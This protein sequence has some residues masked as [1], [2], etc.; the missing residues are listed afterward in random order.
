MAN[1]IDNNNPQFAFLPLGSIK[2]KWMNLVFIII[3]AIAI[4]TGPSSPF[5]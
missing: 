5:C 4:I 2:S 1:E 3:T